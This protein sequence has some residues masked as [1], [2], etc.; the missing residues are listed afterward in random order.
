MAERAPLTSAQAGQSSME[1]ES[2]MTKM[3]SKV[4]RKAYGSSG[5]VMLA[6]E[7]TE[8]EGDGDRGGGASE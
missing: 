7:M 5:V 1:L 2:S 3:V 4:A 8:G 6:A